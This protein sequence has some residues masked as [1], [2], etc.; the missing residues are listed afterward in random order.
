MSAALMLE[1]VAHVYPLNERIIEWKRL[2]DIDGDLPPTMD[3]L[4]KLR[5]FKIDDAMGLAVK[6]AKETN[7]DKLLSQIT[8]AQLYIEM[9]AACAEVELF[10]VNTL[11]LPAYAGPDGGRRVMENHIVL[12]KNW[13]AKGLAYSSFM[14]LRRASLVEPPVI[15]TSRCAVLEKTLEVVSLDEDL[16]TF[17]ESLGKAVREVWSKDLAGLCAELVAMCPAW[18]PLR[19]H[20]LDPEHADLVLAMATNKKHAAISAMTS[21][22]SRAMKLFG[23]L[24]KDKQELLVDVETMAEAKKAAEFGTETAAY[25][26]FFQMSTVSW[27]KDGIDTREKAKI[28]VGL[29]REELR[30]T[31]VQLTSQ[32]DQ[33]LDRWVHFQLRIFKIEPVW[34]FNYYILKKSGPEASR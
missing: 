34:T 10:R 9:F 24:H 7:D 2:R 23:S 33:L 26:Y 19:E 6:W 17:K 20:L 15:D 1:E 4:A 11:T 13:R 22:I 29:L 18:A 12:L 8:F 32:M 5:D 16:K 14:N 28:A 31:H 27:V 3:D 30:H 25:Q 21:E